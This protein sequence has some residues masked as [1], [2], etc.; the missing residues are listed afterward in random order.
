MRPTRTKRPALS[1]DYVTEE[2]LLDVI[3][4][5]E[6]EA[7]EANRRFQA[8]EKRKTKILATKLR[9]EKREKSR[10]EMIQRRL[11]DGDGKVAGVKELEETSKLDQMM[12][13]KNQQKPMT[14]T[15]TAKRENGHVLGNWTSQVAEKINELRGQ[16]KVPNKSPKIQMTTTLLP[17]LTLENGGILF[18]TN[19]VGAR[20]KQGELAPIDLQVT[21]SPTTPQVMIQEVPFESGEHPPSLSKTPLL[22]DMNDS[23]IQE[24]DLDLSLLF[25]PPMLKSVDASNEPLKA[26]TSLVEPEIIPE[27]VTNQEDSLSMMKNLS[28]TSNLSGLDQSH[29]F[30]ENLAQSPVAA[31]SLPPDLSNNNNN[32][33]PLEQNFNQNLDLLYNPEQPSFNSRLANLDQVKRMNLPLSLTKPFNSKFYRNPVIAPG[34]WTWIFADTIVAFSGNEYANQNNQYKYILAVVCALSRK[35]KVRK[36]VTNTA[37]ETAKNLNSIFME[38][39]PDLPGHTFLCTDQG[40]EFQKETYQMLDQWAIEPVH[41]TGRHKASVVERFK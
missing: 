16:P 19:V 27:V 8:E 12:N 4:Q 34:L 21:S 36:Q 38:I 37:I 2:F 11:Q 7:R 32:D 18:Q 5:R 35:S 29:Q 28:Q 33:Q 30:E 9:N 20:N 41:L 24:K 22:N 31:S 25:E 23:K 26:T 13:S 3:N 1:Q 40:G 14:M 17:T 6:E 10:R 15:T 39:G